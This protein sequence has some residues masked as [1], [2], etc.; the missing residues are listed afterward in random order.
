MANLY[1]AIGHI[2]PPPRAARDLP[3]YQ[4]IVFGQLH[5]CDVIKPD[6]AAKALLKAIKAFK[7][8]GY[9]TGIEIKERADNGRVWKLE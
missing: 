2:L 9:T 1:S 8:P 5:S 6:R 7:A 3:P 4:P